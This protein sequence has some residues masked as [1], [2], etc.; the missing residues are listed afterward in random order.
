MNLIY[1]EVIEVLSEP[2]YKEEVFED[3]T[4]GYWTIKVKVVDEGGEK[5]ENLSFDNRRLAEKVSVG[6]KYLH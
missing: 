4:Y 6:Y 1:A 2:E 3:S 5:T